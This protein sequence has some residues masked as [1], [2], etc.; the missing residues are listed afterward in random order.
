MNPKKNWI[1]LCMIILLMILIVFM[2][3][4]LKPAA[5]QRPSSSI[6]RELNRLSGFR[7]INQYPHDPQAYTQGLI[8][9]EGY[10]Y[11][12]T[13]LRGYST[14]RKV[15]LGSGEVV[16]MIELDNAFYAEGLTLWNE[17]LVQLTWQEQIGFIYDLDDF[18]LVD[19]FYYNTEGWGL[20]HDDSNLIMSDGTSTLFFLDPKTLKVVRTVEVSDHGTPVTR[21]NEL[22]YVLGEVYANI[23]QTN[24]IVRIDPSTGLV[25]GWID[26]AG[27]LPA[28]VNPG[29]VAVLNG[30]AYDPIQDRLFVTGKLWPYLFEI[31][32]VDHP[33]TTH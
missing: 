32:L 26:L 16:Q 27:L 22:E 3:V 30:I 23:W 25:N 4:R 20:T 14:L 31:A 33:L 5:H 15:D 6:P 10:L 24:N 21:I 7:V 8:F 18:T 13:G 9:H 19:T 12:S 17:T 28:D 2:A 29:S 11:E 1:W